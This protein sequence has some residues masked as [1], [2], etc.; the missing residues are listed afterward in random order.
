MAIFLPPF[1]FGKVGRK[2]SLADALMLD[3]AKKTDRDNPR[4][5]QSAAGIV[6]RR[7]QTRQRSDL[8]V[9]F[10]KDVRRNYHNMHDTD[11]HDMLTC[12]TLRTS[13]S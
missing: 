13:Y 10:R 3:K 11:V 6:L 2:P 1:W 12:M 7:P 8:R 5:H 9:D 4:I